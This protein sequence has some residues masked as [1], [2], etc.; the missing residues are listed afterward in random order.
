MKYLKKYKDE[1][2]WFEITREKALEN[3]RHYYG[4]AEEVLEMLEKDKIPEVET[5]F[6]FL[7]VER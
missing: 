5:P 2:K 3:I 4:N 6:A 7:K 1:D